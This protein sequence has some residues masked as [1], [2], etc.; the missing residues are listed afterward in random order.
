MKTISITLTKE[1]AQAV[2][3][4]RYRVQD[5]PDKIEWAGNRQAFSAAD[6]ILLNFIDDMG[7]LERQVA[8]QAGLCNATYTIE[9]LGGEAIFSH[10]I[11]RGPSDKA[12]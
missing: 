3:T 5:W 9:D 6:G 10:D 8:F 4:H 1:G 2:C 11:V 7:N 12:D